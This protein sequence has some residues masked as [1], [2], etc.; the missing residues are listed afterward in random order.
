MPVNPYRALTRA[1]MA[2]LPLRSQ[3]VWA[4]LSSE[5]RSMM[6]SDLRSAADSVVLP[7]DSCSSRSSAMNSFTTDAIGKG[8]LAPLETIWPVLRSSTTVSMSAARLGRVGGGLTDAGVESVEWRRRLGGWGFGQRRERGL[9]GDNWCLRGVLR[10]RRRTP[11]LCL[12]SVYEQRHT[13]DCHSRH[14]PFR[15]PPT[16]KSPPSRS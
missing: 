13:D 4:A 10:G 11:D 9:R 8:L 15:Q 6:S 5:E 16:H 14:R 12:T 7:F 1:M 3:K 2:F